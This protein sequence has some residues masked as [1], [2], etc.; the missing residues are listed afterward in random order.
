[1][2]SAAVRRETV[3]IR[4]KQLVSTQQATSWTMNSGFR[5]AMLHFRASIEVQPRDRE[6][7]GSIWRRLRYRQF[8]CLAG[9]ALVV[10]DRS[11]SLAR[12]PSSSGNFASSSASEIPNAPAVALFGA[13]NAV[14][15]RTKRPSASPKFEA[16]FTAP[17]PARS[18]LTA[19]TRRVLSLRVPP[20]P[21]LAPPPPLP[22]A[23]LISTP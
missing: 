19:S 6:K 12:D 14:T 1:M 16:P 17:S 3:L 15:A 7:C 10:R 2:V 20:D 13:P 5:G 23:L 9:H 22:L 4:G 11:S 21:G 8:E 18:P